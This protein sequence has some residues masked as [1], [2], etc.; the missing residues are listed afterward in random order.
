MCPDQLCRLKEVL[1]ARGGASSA[2][3]SSAKDRVQHSTRAADPEAGHA[4]H[5]HHHLR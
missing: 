3:G 1:L 2:A 4:G 5:G